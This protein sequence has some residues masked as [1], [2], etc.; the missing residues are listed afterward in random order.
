[1]TIHLV[2]CHVAGVATARN[3]INENIIQKDLGTLRLEGYMPSKAIIG[4]QRGRMGL[5]N[6]AR[7]ILESS[8]GNK[9]IN[10]GRVAYYTYR[11]SS[12]HVRRPR[13]HIRLE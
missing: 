8:N 9:G 1:M 11:H 3:K 6:I 5:P 4:R 2:D 7:S 12:I 10:V 13:L